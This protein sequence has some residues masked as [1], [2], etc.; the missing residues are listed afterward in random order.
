MRS[1]FLAICLVFAGGFFAAMNA[2]AVAADA[3]AGG[4]VVRERVATRG[5]VERRI[6]G[7]EGCTV[8]R[9]CRT[10]CPD[11]YSCYPL[12]GAYGPYGGVGYW[13][14]YTDAGWGRYR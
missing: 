7:P 14:A 4:R 3:D 12:Y 6:C 9:T 8:R 5:C 13:G 1:L 2:P 11:G 10:G